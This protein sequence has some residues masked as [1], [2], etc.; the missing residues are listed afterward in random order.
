MSKEPKLL[1]AAVGLSAGIFVWVLG[2]DRSLS[3]A[4]PELFLL[5]VILL[6]AAVSIV[7]IQ[8]GE[9]RSPEHAKKVS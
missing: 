3:P 1:G 9:P 6:V 2:L 7:I 4:H 5:A 8:R